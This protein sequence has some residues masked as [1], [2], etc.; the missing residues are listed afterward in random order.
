MRIKRRELKQK[1]IQKRYWER[2]KEKRHPNHPVVVATY[3]PLISFISSLGKD[4]ECFNVLD[5]GCGN[6]F[7]SL[8]LEKN[9]NKVVCLDYSYE[10]LKENPCQNKFL[11]SSTNLPFSDKNFDVVVASQLLHHLIERDRKKT[12]NEMIRVAKVA[13]I[14]FEPN[15]NNLAML[16][17][18][19]LK[20]EERMALKF[21]K[22]YMY[23]LFENLPLESFSIDVGGWIVPN[24]APIWW[25]PIGQ[26]LAKTPIQRFGFTISS[27]GRL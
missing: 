5:I 11:G 13:V 4:T 21:S 27:I 23:K 14:S 12:L 25:I 26:I 10:M 7:F 18:N 8:L 3:S 2:D 19:L 22:S 16:L 20:R 6:G 9:F 17:F 15:R 1:R 24:R